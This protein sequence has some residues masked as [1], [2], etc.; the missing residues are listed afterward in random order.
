MV[1]AMKTSILILA[2]T[3]M[4][5]SR[6]RVALTCKRQI[7]WAKDEEGAMIVFAASLNNLHAQAHASCAG[8]R[9]DL[10]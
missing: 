2:T 3:A 9:E 4:S 5:A 1:P 6:T 8:K 10:A 7:H